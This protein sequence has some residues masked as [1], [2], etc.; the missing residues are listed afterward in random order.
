MRRFLLLTLLASAVTAANLPEAVSAD[1]VR[2]PGSIPRPRLFAAP[3]VSWHGWYYEA[4]FGAPL[5]VVVPPTADL[6]TKW[7]W[8][9]G[10]TQ[11]VP[12]WPQFSRNYPGP[13]QYD[14]RL[15][16]STP[17]WPSH[18]DQFGDY[19]VRGPW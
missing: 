14:P 13:S 10:G 11:V 9:V 4:A 5:A 16:R 17:P 8:G 7:G 2:R 1:G 3:V 19:Y 6:Q 12:I 18:T 15:F